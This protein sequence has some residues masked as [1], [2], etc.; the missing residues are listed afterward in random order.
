MQKKGKKLCIYDSALKFNDKLENTTIKY[1]NLSFKEYPECGN[2]IYKKRNS[3][4]GAFATD[5]KN[6]NNKKLI[7][8]IKIYNDY[9]KDKSLPKEIKIEVTSRCNLSCDFCFNVNSFERNSK[10]LPTS[11]IFKIIDKIKKQG[12]KKIRFTGGEPFLRKDIVKL[13][14]YAKSNGLYVKVNTNLELVGKDHIDEL[15]KYVNHMYVSFNLSLKNGN[16]IN[17]KDFKKKIDLIKELLRNNIRV[18]LNTVTTKYNI[19]QLEKISKIIQDIDC[20]WTLL[21]QVP[22][23][24]N[25]NPI[26]NNDVKALV[27]N[28]IKINKNTNKS[29]CITALPF[30]SYDPEKVKQVSI[31]AE[32]CGSFFSLSIGPSGKIKSCYSDNKNL[33]DALKIEIDD[34]WKNGFPRNIR[35]LNLLPNICKE[36]KYVFECLGGCRFA[37]KL[38]NGSYSS[39]DPLAIPEKY[40]N[41]LFNKDEN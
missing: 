32:L 6:L 8:K 25:K 11:Q 33:G 26:N 3:C 9:I 34:V 23:I 30:C 22:T 16:S 15:R 12:I 27:E 14:E 18:G 21:R 38:L 36:C 29:Y 35:E 17:D 10:E 28:L 7:Y 2:C 1:F 20:N 19:K 4:S 41:A 39:L 37:A 5:N 24:N 40:G 13:F 31:G